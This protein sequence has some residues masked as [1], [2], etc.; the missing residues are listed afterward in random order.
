MGCCLI[1][2][3]SVVTT[4]NITTEARNIDDGCVGKI[5]HF[6]PQRRVVDRHPSAGSKPPALFQ[7]I[8]EK[9]RDGNP[10]FCSEVDG[11][12]ESFGGSIEKW[13]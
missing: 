12:R 3:R 6:I 11:N 1:V 2:F 8:P 7:I 10:M 9:S 13:T 4:D 5:E